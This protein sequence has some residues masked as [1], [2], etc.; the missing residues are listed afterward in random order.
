MDKGKH[1]IS[2]GQLMAMVW[3]S[4]LALAVD[5][6]PRLTAHQSGA[7][8]WLAPLAA[9]PAVLGVGYVLYRVTGRGQYGFAQVCRERLGPLAGRVV[10]VVYMVWAVLLGAMRIN[11]TAQRALLASSAGG[12]RRLLLWVITAMAAWLVWGKIAVFARTTVLLYRGVLVCL[13]AVLLLTVSQVHKEN[14]LP[15]W[16]QDAVPVF[17]SAVAVVGT[18]S[19][20][21]YGIFIIDEVRMNKGLVS[22]WVFRSLALCALLSG[23]LAAVI[24]AQGAELTGRLSDPFVTLSKHVGVEGAFQRVESLVC[25]VWL[26]ADLVMIGLL[27]YAGRRIAA[28]LWPA[29]DG[30]LTVGLLAAAM[31]C[32]A[33]VSPE[34]AAGAREFGEVWVPAAGLLLFAG[35]PFLVGLVSWVAHLVAKHGQK[36]QI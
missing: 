26:L 18:V 9:I 7:A 20:G 23:L 3:T 15:L 12:G 4:V 8:G 30:R 10:L 1:C 27:L 22:G 2:P 35:V 16:T 33:A 29:L 28:R 21:L 36:K 31:L 14:I 13:A 5:I 34:G 17:R 6:L 32:A 25:A 11:M 19:C 24:G